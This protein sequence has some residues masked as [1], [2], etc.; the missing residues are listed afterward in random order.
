MDNNSDVR[1]QCQQTMDYEKEPPPAYE[2][3]VHFQANYQEPPPYPNYEF[4][5][6]EQISK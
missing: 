4:S 5:R 6:Q 3:I 1:D 2:T